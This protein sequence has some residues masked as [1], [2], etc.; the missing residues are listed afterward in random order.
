M[1]R[2]SGVFRGFAATIVALVPL[3]AYCGEIRFDDVTARAGLIGPLAGMM[4]HGG[5]VGD[6]DDDGD[7]DLFVG[8][9]CD[10]PDA[11]YA[12]ATKPVSSR[13]FRNRGDG[14]F[15]PVEST[16][17]TFH[18]RTSGA[19]FADLDNNGTLELYVA[20]NRKQQAGSKAGLQREATLCPSMLLRND[21]KRL[22]DISAASGGC[23]P[24]MGTARNVGVF[25]YNGDGLLDLL[26]V[27]DRFTRDP[28]SVLL[29][30]LGNLRFEDASRDAGLPDDLFGLG[31]AVADLN[32]DGRPDFFVGHSNRFFLSAGDGTYREPPELK[33]VF[34]W[35]PLHNEDWPCG[36]AFG[37]L[38]RDGRLDMVLAVHC[39]RARNRVFL[40]DGLKKGIPQFRD[41]TDRVGLPA[42]VP[43]KCPHVEIQDFDNDG[44]PDIYFSAAWLDASGAIT[45]L[46]FR[47][48]GLRD[49]LPRFEPPRPIEPPMVYFSTG[50]SGDFDRDGR[51]DLF[52]VNWFENNHSRLMRNVSRPR[53]WLDVQV[54]GTRMNRMGIGTQIRVYRPGKAGKPDALLGFQ[55]VAIG[56]GYAAGQEAICHF[57]LGDA[58]TVDMVVRFPD[59]IELVER[60]VAVDRRLVIQQP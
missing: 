4:G 15:E 49:G 13:L 12:P 52:L 10:R 2:L 9:F 59:G 11:M 32:E 18:G 41:V 29:R 27:E 25:D 22:I 30:N 53:H 16:P 46:V 54:V 6:I 23:P 56:Y 34:A 19:V 44:L 24:S 35:D 39:V 58:T 33:R 48:T 45:P 40:N 57:G 5:A 1:H 21:G 47:N 31:L 36:A 14:T 55:E 60:S 38:N 26:L 20:N 17:A 50:P 51:I 7:L 3:S 8:G 37:D 43:Q 28:K 42:E